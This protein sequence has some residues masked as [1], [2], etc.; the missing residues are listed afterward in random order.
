MSNSLSK[1]IIV[2]EHGCAYRFCYEALLENPICG[3]TQKEN[4]LHY[5]D[6]ECSTV[7]E[8]PVSFKEVHRQVLEKLG[9]TSEE[10]KQKALSHICYY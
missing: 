10:E 5:S 7:E 8:S 2:E 3:K 9:I 1:I 6:E 4:R